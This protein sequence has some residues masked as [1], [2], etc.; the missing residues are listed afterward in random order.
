MYEHTSSL[1]SKVLVGILLLIF[2]W[3]ISYSVT[4][5]GY[6]WNAYLRS[7]VDLLKSLVK[8]Q[9]KW[10]KIYEDNNRKLSD[11]EKNQFQSESKSILDSVSV[12][13]SFPVP[14]IVQF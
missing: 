14:T 6:N 2:T 5:L 9:S 4:F 13:C 8:C 7:I 1:F 12:F 11:A 10:Q 3:A